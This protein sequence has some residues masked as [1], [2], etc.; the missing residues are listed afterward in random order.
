M[1]ATEEATLGS[2]W[3]HEVDLLVVGSGAGGLTGALAAAHAGLDTLV[4]EKSSVYGGSTALSGGGLWIPNNP[5]L[6]REGLGDTR[7]DI[8]AY[9]DAVV[10]DRVPT[11]NL[12]RFIDDGPRM[13]EFL[14]NT[15]PDLRFQWRGCGWL[16]RT[17]VSRCG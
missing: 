8:R 7:A 6:L 10:G 14:E 13:V 2:Q 17:R 9:L 4:I 11:H 3:D 5:V 16:P 1:P 12:D 15:G